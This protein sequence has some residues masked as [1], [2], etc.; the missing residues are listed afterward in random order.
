MP[1]QPVCAVM[2]AYHPNE[3]T[4]DNVARILAQVQGLVIVDN[5]S[6]ADEVNQLRMASEAL[7]YELIENGENVGVAEALNQGV[8]WAKKQSYPW[9]I[10][11]DQDSAITDGFLGQLFVA[12]ES[13]TDR[14]RVGSIHP[15]YLDHDT[16]S[17]PLI[18]RAKRS[19]SAKE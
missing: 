3:R 16:G 18:R 1:E 15:L 5:G 14:E 12:W 19:S 11:F 10:L 4:L 6:D 9:V 17:E 7:G 2:V 8:L 13:R